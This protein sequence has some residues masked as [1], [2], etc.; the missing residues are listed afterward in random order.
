MGAHLG[1]VE[2]SRSFAS[3]LRDS[4]FE[5]LPTAAYLHDINYSLAFART[6]F[7]LLDYAA[8]FLRSVGGPSITGHHAGGKRLAFC[9]VDT[10]GEIMEPAQLSQDSCGSLRRGQARKA[11]A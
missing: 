8:R 6:G 4:G 3:V 9:T 2:R 1:V 5:V 7:H 10:A 11:V